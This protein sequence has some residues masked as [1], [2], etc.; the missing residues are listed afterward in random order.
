MELKKQIM[1]THAL[2]AIATLTLLFCSSCGNRTSNSVT[3]DTLVIEDSYRLEP[4]KNETLMLK[5]KDPFGEIIELK[6]EQ[7]IMDD[8]IFKPLESQMIIKNNFLLMQNRP[9][10]V[11]AINQTGE[12]RI[13]PN[14]DDPFTLGFFTIFRLPEMELVQTFGIIG[15]GPDEFMFPH[16]CKNAEPDVLATIL[17]SSNGKLYDVLFDGSLRLSNMRIPKSD[18][19]AGYYP[20]LKTASELYFVGTSSTGKSVFVLNDSSQVSEIQ[21]LGLDRRR[22]GWANYIGDFAMNKNQTCMVYAYKYFKIVTFF[23][24]EYGAVRTLNFA[25]EEFDESTLEF[26]DGMDKNVTHYWGISTTEK[27]VYIAYSGRTPHQ[28]WEQNKRGNLYIFIEKYDWNGNPIAKYKLDRWG[29]FAVTENT[30]Y[31][32]STNDDDPFFRY[33]LN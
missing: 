18:G 29:Y 28:V 4:L 3:N 6:G 16:L 26:F 19:Y 31:L 32:I 2:L 7:I 9:R 30:L 25:K 22:R 5:N 20:A 27:H 11:L 15:N 14:N 24:L 23:D 33:Q 21:N 13:V 1:R 12:Q 10:G 17:E 8:I